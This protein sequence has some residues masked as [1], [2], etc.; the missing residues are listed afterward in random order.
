[1]SRRVV[2]PV[3]AA[4]LVAAVGLGYLAGSTVRSFERQDGAGW[5]DSAVEP[6]WLQIPAPDVEFRTPEGSAAHLS[7]YHGQIVLLNFWGTW[8]PPCLVEIP[9]LIRVQKSLAGLGGTIVGPA[10]DSG[11]G[12]SVLKFAAEHGI[13]YPIWMSDS[14]TAVS[15]FGAAG[16]P[17]TLL[18]DRDGVIRKVY[19]GPQ[20]SR[21]LLADVRALD[22]AGLPP[23]EVTPPRQPSGSPSGSSS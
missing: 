10:V 12:E 9:H 23:A 11:S 3:G 4:I 14:E 16:F 7:D 5:S 21:G 22:D 1:M 8:C 2:L 17:F 6:S 19:L 13:N 20:T 18:I 15:R